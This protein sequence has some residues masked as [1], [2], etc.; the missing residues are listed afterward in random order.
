[1]SKRMNA[2]LFF[3]VCFV[4]LLE[5]STRGGYSYERKS[6]SGLHS[7][8][9][10]ARFWLAFLGLLDVMAYQVRDIGIVGLLLEDE[11]VFRDRA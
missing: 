8:S 6:P 10:S 9:G 7:K 3:A 1:M 4:D 2:G 5:G 11:I